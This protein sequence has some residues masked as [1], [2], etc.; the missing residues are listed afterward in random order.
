MSTKELAETLHFSVSNISYYLRFLQKQN[1][2]YIASYRKVQ[3]QDK[4]LYCPFYKFGSLPD[5][6]KPKALT[7]SE[8]TKRNRLKIL[9]DPDLRD[10]I[11]AKRRAAKI[12]PKIDWVS[13]WIPR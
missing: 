10:F 7:S 8:K 6:I 3:Y 13:S 9:S 5:A 11:N 12:K 1:C 4:K 2:V